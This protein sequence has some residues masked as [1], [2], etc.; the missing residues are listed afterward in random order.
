MASEREYK[1]LVAGAFPDVERL[2]ERYMLEGLELRTQGVR[3]QEDVYYDTP[4]LTLLHA[5]VALRRRRFEG[6]NLATYKGS[7]TVR[8]GLHTRDEVELPYTESWPDEI[9]GRLEPLGVT[10]ELRPLLELSARRERFLVV[11]GDEPQAELTFDEV[12]GRDLTTM[13]PE[14]R[15]RELEVELLPTTKGDLGNLV[16]PLDLPELMPHAGDKLSHALHLLGWL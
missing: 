12:A 2:R 13:R 9:L 3:E 4:A 10:G 11:S 6:Q 16:A 8:D 14:V 7:G 15:F 1:F 5:G